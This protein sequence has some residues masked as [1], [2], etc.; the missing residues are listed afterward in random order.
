MP[1]ISDL[2]VDNFVDRSII[3]K[4]KEKYSD[5]YLAAS[6][7]S[8]GTINLIT[9]IIALYFE[10]NTINNLTIIEEPERNM[11]PSLISGMVDMM[12][13][14]SI[15]KQ[16]II[17]THNPELLKRIGLESLFLIS[18]DKEGYSKIINPDEKEE[19]KLF[20][21]NDIGIEELFIQNLLGF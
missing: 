17:T 7:I 3:F 20:L 16:I 13:D 4:L 10:K 18:R 12:K 11:H 5:E 6:F 8:D 1:F 14:A 15:E 9:L 19:I 2:E 21:K